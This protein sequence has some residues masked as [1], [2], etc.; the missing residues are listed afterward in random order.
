MA[1]YCLTE[2]DSGSDAASLTTKAIRNG[3]IYSLSGSKAFISGGGMSDIY[4][5]MAQTEHLGT[6]LGM[7]AFIVHKVRCR[8]YSLTV[9]QESAAFVMM[10][11]Y[12]RMLVGLNQ[13]I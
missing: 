11:L 3:D 8:M 2:P 12:P 6:S 13:T 5:V 1:S 4:L 9:I 7:S 10:D